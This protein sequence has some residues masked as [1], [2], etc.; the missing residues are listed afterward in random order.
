V[1]LRRLG[2]AALLAAVP[3][4]SSCAA[5]T[6][7]DTAEATGGALSIYSSL[8]LQGPDAPIAEQLIGGEKLA[9]AQASGHAGHFKIGYVSLDDADPTKGTWDPGITASNAKRAAQDP[10][11]IAYLG[12]FNSGATAVSLPLIN[13]AG[14][15]QVSPASPY[16]GLTSALDAGQDEP[17]RF[18][19]SGRRTFARLTPGDPAESRAQL[20]LMKSLGVHSAYVLD[21]QN[22]FAVPLAMIL[23]GQLASGG[24]HLAAHESIATT[25][26]A[27]YAKL[28]EKI[29]ASGAD[30]VF[31]AGEGSAPGEGKPAAALWRAIHRADPQLKLLASSGMLTP[32]FVSNLGAAATSTYLTTPVLSASSYPPVAQHVLADYRRSFGA[33]GGPWA[34]YGYEAM[35]LVLDAIAAAGSHA[36]DRREVI[37]RMFDAPA[38]E[39]V[40]GPVAITKSGEST[41]ARY[42]VD[43]VRGGAPVFLRT[44]SL[45][46]PER[47]GAAAKASG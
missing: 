25:P 5:S 47:A 7:P 41:L 11:T 36:T 14:V 2:L 45:S 40:L 8:P 26:G 9:L 27:S 32:G 46:A 38:R 20:A 21:D 24:I 31:L 18:Y 1:L 22:P 33:E 15:L 35:R 3:I 4:L 39:T 34:L 19:P 17:E 44:V 37:A 28:V 16:V 42:G 10:S 12:D 23:A 30:A 13:G 29:S 43:T 6:S